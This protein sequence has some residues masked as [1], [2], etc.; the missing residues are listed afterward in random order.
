MQGAS[1]PALCVSVIERAASSRAL[2]TLLSLAADG[3]FPPA[4]GG[5]EILRQPAERDAGVISLT[6]FAVVFADT[7]PVWIAGQLPDGDLSAPLSPGFLHALGQRL[8]REPHSIDMLTCASAVLGRPPA[9]LELTELDLGG[10]YVADTG[11]ADRDLADRD[12][13]DRSPA[14]PTRTAAPGT[15]ARIAR[16]LRYRDD[17]RVWQADGGIVALGRGVAGRWEV[18]VEVEP[19]FRGRGLGSRLASA[20]RHLAPGGA[21]VWAQIAPGNAA[22]VRTF[23]RAGFRPVG[24]EA[25]LT[26]AT[27]S[28]RQ[29]AAAGPQRP[30]RSQ[31]AG[32]TTASMSD[33]AV[34]DNRDGSRLEISADGELAELVY[35]TRPGRLILVHTGV[36]ATLNGRGLGGELVRAAVRKATQEGMTLVPLCPFARSWLER[37]ADEAAAVSIGWTAQ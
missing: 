24:A 1:G 28:T 21:T 29:S 23:L 20:A 34:T 35:R 16:A 17:V 22:S 10:R 3:Q 33:T 31:G 14:D 4:N 27:A 6:G 25:L 32:E 19:D 12:L 9:E 30:A 7:D 36:P 37:H 15:H 13:A 2:A 18:S 8:G 5:V 26:S 11:L